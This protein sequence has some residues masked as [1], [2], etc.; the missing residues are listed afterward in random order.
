MFNKKIKEQIAT[1]QDAVNKLQKTIETQELTRLRANNNN[2]KEMC[3]D[4]S[5]L[6]L[7]VKSTKVL[8]DDNG[9]PYVEIRYETPVVKMPINSNGEI[10]RN[11]FFR[12][13]NRLNLLSQEDVIKLSNFLEEAKQKAKL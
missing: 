3:E 11:D 12:S 2:Y 7:K 6:A 5:K 13:V 8:L 1:L 4:V 9:Y 10:L